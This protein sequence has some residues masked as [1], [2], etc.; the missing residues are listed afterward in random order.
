MK[1]ICIIG[2]GSIGKYVFKNLIQDNIKIKSLIC[3]HGR[4]KEGKQALGSNLEIYNSINDFKD[5]PDIILDC[6]GHSALKDHASKALLKGI[7][8]IT[9]SSGCLLYTSPSPRDS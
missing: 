1:N 3:R 5:Y 9:L 7:N 4:E 2:F 6:A 8:F